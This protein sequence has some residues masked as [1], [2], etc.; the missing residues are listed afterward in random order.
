MNESVEAGASDSE[1]SPE[2]LQSL[3]K[4]LETVLQAEMHIILHGGEAAA[5]VTASDGSFGFNDDELEKRDPAASTDPVRDYLKSIGRVRLLSAVQEADLALRI[6]AG[7]YAEKKLASDYSLERKHRRELEWVMHDGRRAKNHL[8][9]A[10][11]RL[12]VSLA[13]RYTGRGMLFL[14]LIQ[15]GNLGLIRAVEKFDYRKGFKFSTYA[16]WWIRQAITRAMA[17]QARTIRIPVH[18]V[19]IIN[20]LA[21]VE[22]QMLQDLGRDA[23]IDELASAMEMLPEKI[24]EVQS[25]GREPFSLNT[26]IDERETEL[27]DILEDPASVGPFEVMSFVLLRESIRSC[28]SRFTAREVS[29]ISHRFGLGDGQPKTLDE[30]GKM[31]GVTRERIRQIE[32]QVMEKL[33]SPAISDH[34]RDFAD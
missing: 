23:S 8:I 26:I 4:E 12:V 13:K 18:M 33:R 20:K 31:H 24:S 21:R 22:R 6:E 30:I 2:F 17:D 25:Y 5:T 28:L 19:E 29:V 32:K 16:T 27:G 34:L 1:V 9:E 3:E 10:N 15:E 11:L 14:D 7:L